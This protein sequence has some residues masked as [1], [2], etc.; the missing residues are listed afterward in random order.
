MEPL[1]QSICRSCRT[2]LSRSVPSATRA[3]SSSAATQAIPPES[4]HFVDVPQSFQPDFI[5][6]PKKKGYLPTPKDIFPPNLPKKPTQAYI[7][8]LAPEPKNPINVNDPNIP[9]QIRYKARMTALRKTHLRSSLKELHVRKTSLLNRVQLRSQMKQI[10]SQRLVH[11]PPR[12]DERLTNVS[13]P[14]TMSPSNKYH[15][16]PAEALEEHAKKVANVQR[17]AAASEAERTDQLHTLYMNARKFITDEEQLKAA[18]QEEFREDKFGTIGDQSIWASDGRPKGTKEL[19]AGQW[20]GVA[21]TQSEKNTEHDARE[22][23]E[24]ERMKRIGE[25]LSGGKI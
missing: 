1:S 2:R 7:D 25:R 24:R 10:Q 15:F 18:V 6:R 12:E 11:Q 23:N 3:F 9:A 19:L 20:T 4:P 5:G 8:A 22:K 14:S 16:T 13:I 17:H 21:G